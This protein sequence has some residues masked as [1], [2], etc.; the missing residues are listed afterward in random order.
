MDLNKNKGVTIYDSEKAYNGINLFYRQDNALVAMDM[1]GKYV[2]EWNIT[3]KGKEP[4]KH[5]VLM[6]NCSVLAM[7]RN[8][9]LGLFNKNSE[10]LWTKKIDAHHS[11]Q[12]YNNTIYVLVSKYKYLIKGNKI[13]NVSDDEIQVLSINGTIMS[14]TSL[15]SILLKN[16][17]TEYI[18]NA[19][20]TYSDA[21]KFSSDMLHSNSLEVINKTYNSYLKQGYILISSRHIN[22]I[23]IIDPEKQEL[24]WFYN[25]GLE[26][27]HSAKVLENGNIIIFNNGFYRG[28]SSVMEINPINNNVVW[29]YTAKPIKQT[30][31]SA[32]QGAVRMLPNGNFLITES[33]KDHIFEITRKGEKVWEYWSPDKLDKG[34]ATAIFS[35]ERID[36]ETLRPCFE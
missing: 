1:N 9:A 6:E 12:I 33:R 30:F 17:S 34:R 3:F 7:Q 19:S 23:S 24:I 18:L 10:N 5:F 11:M 2:Y 25:K 27:Q 26:G 22:A 16:I 20:S 32:S 35:T 28:Y 15:L 21:N 4:A 29:E 14:K 36:S 13:M 31:F 8:T